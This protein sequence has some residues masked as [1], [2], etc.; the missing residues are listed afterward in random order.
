MRHRGFETCLKEATDKL[1]ACDAIYISF[2]VDSMDSD[3]IS[4]GT[5]TPVPKGFDKEEVI[6]IIGAVIATDKVACFEV[7]EVN[8]TLDNKGNLMAETAF[9]VIKATTNSILKRNSSFTFQ[10]TNA[11]IYFTL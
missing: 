7:V 2:D 4:K 6:K 8:P 9:D 5:G 10:C 1:N 11:N 3:L